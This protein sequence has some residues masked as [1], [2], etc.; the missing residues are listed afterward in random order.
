MPDL[1]AGHSVCD[2]GRGRVAHHAALAKTPSMAG[3]P[4]LGTFSVTVG[5]EA[6]K[7]L[8]GI[9][10]SATENYNSKSPPTPVQLLEDY[11]ERL[12]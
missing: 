3:R 9:H 4:D 12:H 1:Q 8:P 5:T 10:C 11:V 6:W 7:N 2:Y